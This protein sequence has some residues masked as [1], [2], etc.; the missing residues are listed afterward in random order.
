VNN[1]LSLV[2]AST[3]DIAAQFQQAAQAN[4]RLGFTIEDSLASYTLLFRAT[5]SVTESM[6]ANQIAMDLSRATGNDLAGS[7]KLVELAMEGNGRALKQFGINLKD[8]LSPGEALNELQQKLAGTA[9]D[10]V[11]TPWGQLDVAKAKTQELSA[12]L[13]NA[14]IPVLMNFL[15]AVTPI[16]TKLTEWAD[17]HPKLTTFILITIGVVGLLALAVSGI[18]A[19]VSAAITIFFALSTVLSAAAVVIGAVGLPVIALGVLVGVLAY[20]W[21]TRWNEIKGGVQVVLEF[22]SNL[23]T[24]WSDNITKLWTNLWNTI[25][26]IVNNILSAISRV[27]SGVSSIA[28]SVGGAVSGVAGNVGGAF[29]NVVHAFASGGIVTGPTLALVGEAGPEA[30]IPLSA[31]AGGPGLTGAG[32]GGGAGSV[33]VNILGGNYLD[34]NGATMIANAIGKQIV[35]QLKVSNFN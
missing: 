2:G 5:D 13:G 11:N 12:T 18:A 16:I 33:V 23:F 27:T 14:L 6:K 17:A 9:Q 20:L 28:G 8:G 4:T 35:R 34:S 24:T 30:I 26:G 1:S 25:S 3:Q 22:L 31:F 19:A 10:Y 21:I 29:Q 7:A 32:R 15:Q